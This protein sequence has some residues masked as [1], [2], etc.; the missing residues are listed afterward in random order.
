MN[1]I[2]QVENI[3]SLTIKAAAEQEMEYPAS[4]RIHPELLLKI[5]R[6]EGWFRHPLFYVQDAGVTRFGPNATTSSPVVS[7]VFVEGRVLPIVEDPH[8]FLLH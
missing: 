4:L 2:D 5:S 6:I 7:R 8:T 3:L 1:L